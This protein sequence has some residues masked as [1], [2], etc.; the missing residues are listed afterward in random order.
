MKPKVSGFYQHATPVWQKI[1]IKNY[2]R[3]CKT[4]LMN[5]YLF[6]NKCMDLINT[7]NN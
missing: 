4:F 1:T 5:F 7:E 2:K 6:V 3:N